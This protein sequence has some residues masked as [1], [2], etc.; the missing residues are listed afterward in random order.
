MTEP[1]SVNNSGNAVK[2]QG[3]RGYHFETTTLYKLKM[4]QMRGV[5]FI[6]TGILHSIAYNGL[7]TKILRT[8]LNFYQF[9]YEVFVISVVCRLMREGMSI[10][11]SSD[12]CFYKHS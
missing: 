11:Q 6:P 2:K 12:S 7:E 9:V 5:Y 1:V 10:V 4:H 8:F 3:V